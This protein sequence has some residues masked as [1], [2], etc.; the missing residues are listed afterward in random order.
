MFL[1]QIL[2]NKRWCDYIIEKL[3]TLV[4]KNSLN[5]ELEKFLNIIIHSNGYG[6]F[7]SQKTRNAIIQIMN[8]DKHLN[9]V[10]IQDFKFIMGYQAKQMDIELNEVDHHHN[11]TNIYRTA[12]WWKMEESSMYFSLRHF[13]F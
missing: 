8:P 11:L 4:S 13:L 6:E 2:S 5:I 1:N 3:N 12:L 7:V 10:N 9:T